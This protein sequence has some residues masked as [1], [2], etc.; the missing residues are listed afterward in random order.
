MKVRFVTTLEADT[1][2]ALKVLA[3][4]Q[5]KPVNAIIEEMVKQAKGKE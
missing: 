3:A 2:T 5:H 1:I 4:E